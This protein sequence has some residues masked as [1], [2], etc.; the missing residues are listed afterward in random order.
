[1]RAWFLSDIH[2]RGREDNR[3]AILAHFLERLISGELGEISHLFL[4]G[5][6]FDLWVGGH[7]EFV[8]EYAVLVECFRRLRAKRV[9]IHYFEGNHDLHLSRFW[10]D[11]L[12]VQ[13]HVVPEYFELDGVTI[14]VEHGDQM[15]PDDHGYLMLRA[16]LRTSV[17][18]WL[19]N[20]LPGSTV[21]AIG[22]FMSRASRSWTHSKFKRPGEVVDKMRAMILRHAEAAYAARPFDFIFT[23]HV[24]VHDHQQLSTL[25]KEQKVRSVNLGCWP[26][27]DRFD[28]SDEQ[29]L[30]Y[31]LELKTDSDGRKHGEVTSVLI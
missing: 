5:D 19:S 20:E 26:G 8:R 18:R 3:V 31:V 17:M 29:P 11:Q 30:A 21:M 23:G 16:I 15:N 10:R 2:L 12:D 4:V 13:T 24:H 25:A 9:E 7:E 6:I 28:R 27:A 1:M 22:R 14:R